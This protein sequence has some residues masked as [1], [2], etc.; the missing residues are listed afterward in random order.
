MA[1][2]S[3]DA[4][5]LFFALP[6]MK[7]FLKPIGSC[8]TTAVMTSAMLRFYSLPAVGAAIPDVAS[9]DQ[10]TGETAVPAES[11][12]PATE[13]GVEAPVMIHPI[14]VSPSPLASPSADQPGS[15][16]IGPV[17]QAKPS[18]EQSESPSLPL[19]ETE[20]VKPQQSNDREGTP[21]PSTVNKPESSAAQSIAGMRQTLE[22]R[23]AVIA[24]TDKTS[25]EQQW[26]QNLILTAL[27]AAWR[28]E[29]DRARQIA[30]HPALPAFVRAELLGKIAVLEAQL[31]PAPTQP[32]AIAAKPKQPAP[33]QSTSASPGGRSLP[34]GQFSSIFP[35]LNHYAGTDQCPPIGTTPVGSTPV[36]STPSQ[37]ANAKSQTA[38]P[39]NQANVLA[40]VP[41]WSANLAARIVGLSQTAPGSIPSVTSNP[42]PRSLPRADLFVG[43]ASRLQAGD[44]T[45]ALPAIS[46]PAISSPAI[47]STPAPAHST[48]ASAIDLTVPVQPTLVPAPSPDRPSDAQ[49]SQP[50]PVSPPEQPQAE[51][52]LTFALMPLP[53][54]TLTQSDS[55]KT[56]KIDKTDRLQPA[57]FNLAQAELQLGNHETWIKSDRSIFPT[58]Q[59]RS[60]Q[61][62]GQSLNAESK[63]PVTAKSQIGDGSFQA[64]IPSQ[65]PAQNIQAGIPFSLFS[66]LIPDSLAQVW[67]WWNPLLSGQSQFGSP[68]SGKAAAL[69]HAQW[70]ASSVD[71]SQPNQPLIA[72]TGLSDLDWWHS[73]EFDRAAPPPLRSAVKH[74]PLTFSTTNAKAT[75]PAVNPATLLA[76]SCARSQLNSQYTGMDLIDP[77]TAKQRGWV[78]MLFPLPIPAVVTSLFGWRIHPISGSLSF[79]TGLDLGAPMGTPVMAALSGQ[80]VAADAMGG[81]GLAVVVEN[82]PMR[83]R[84]LYG[85]LSAIAVQ[86]GDQVEQGELLGWV[87]STGN[88]TG[89]HLHFESIIQTATG[90]TAIDPLANAVAELAARPDDRTDAQ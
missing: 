22:K 64:V 5:F 90:W 72:M 34:A 86:P 77:A 81:Y 20:T 38:H 16:T 25:R 29:F 37:R 12:P 42:Q 63:V 32:H 18:P 17:G 33:T 53:E 6:L 27:Q 21:T 71:R 50:E 85:H 60:T 69:N 80:V 2:S 52:P 49:L 70:N 14:E 66:Q 26:Q 76:I 43:V 73:L 11:L 10:P 46:S 19:N 74:Q 67:Q 54:L 4:Y 89:P 44:W 7:H 28:Q 79:H 57:P 83:Q 65:T 62:I 55:L 51:R 47:S 24:N 15:A 84:N 75:Q 56:D 3:P 13:S 36:G 30:Q 41:H 61:P 82:Q 31:Q 88:S 8:L 68:E 1:K 78:N 48:V 58:D 87:G 39:T 40:M 59:A 45:T 35:N 23:L 9:S